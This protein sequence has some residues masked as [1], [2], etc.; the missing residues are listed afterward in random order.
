MN[1]SAPYHRRIFLSVVCA[2]LLIGGAEEAMASVVVCTSPSQPMH[3]KTAFSP[4]TTMSQLPAELNTVP[5]HCG[6][7]VNAPLPA[8]LHGHKL[9]SFDPYVIYSAT[10][11][12]PFKQKTY[13]RVILDWKA[14]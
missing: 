11:Q 12:P 8:L 6:N 2:L 5:W 4:Q 9:L 10:F 7:G 14:K 13:G 3:R 1:V